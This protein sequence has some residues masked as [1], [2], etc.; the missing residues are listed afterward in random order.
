MIILITC[1]I[2]KKDSEIKVDKVDLYRYHNGEKVQIA[3]PY[4][5]AAEREMFITQYCG[6]CW[7]DIFSEREI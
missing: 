7:K 6:T 4:L 1:R 5:T 3:F 2:C